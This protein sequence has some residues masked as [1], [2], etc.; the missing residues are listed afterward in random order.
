M[1]M[2]TTPVVL[3][4]PR[5]RRRWYWIGGFVLLVFLTPVLFSLVAGWWSDRQMQALY[6]E[7][8]AE[9]PDWRWPDLIASVQPRPGEPNSAEQ[10]ANVRALLVSKA[11][12]LPPTW[13]GKANQKILNYRNS[14]LNAEQIGMLRSAFGALDPT[15]LAEARKLKDMPNGRFPIKAVEN[16]ITMS[17]DY[18]QHV[19]SVIYL[20]SNDAMMRGQE[21]DHDGAIE[22]C[23]A[24]LNAARSLRENPTLIGMLVR[25]AG[26]AIA[27][28][29]VERALGQ[30]EATEESLKKLQELIELEAADD[31][32]HHAMRGERACGQQLYDSMRSGKMSLS[33]I[34]GGTNPGLG[35][36][37]AAMFPGFFMSGYPDYLRMMNEQVK[38]AKLTDPERAEAYRKFDDRLRSNRTNWLIRMMMPATSKVVEA[39]QRSQAKLRSTAV[40]VAAERYR[41]KHDQWP[42]G[43]KE[44]I[45]E[46]LIKEEYTDPY[47]GKPLRWKRTQTGLIVY[48]I[49]KDKIDDGGK[50]NRDNPIAVGSDIGFELWDRSLRRLPPPVIEEAPK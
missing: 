34:M 18:I 29:A 23:Q 12:M 17:M 13:D 47:D 43:I 41:L 35:E 38:V 31:G 4:K 44:L 26:R 33:E 7:I 15:T 46:G 2:S 27:M 28:D 3:A 40:A 9:D 19:R 49:S 37:L 21:K 5:S 36:K 14:H 48:S 39:S 32:L 42:T 45:H 16:P 1:T 10:I 24:A 6:A 11:F 30:G 8:D 22:S 25:I 20:L 50:L